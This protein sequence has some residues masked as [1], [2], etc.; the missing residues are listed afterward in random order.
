MLRYYATRWEVTGSIPDDITRFYFSIYLI[1]RA[2]LWS[3]D[4]FSLYQKWVPGI[5][6]G[7]KA[8]PA[9]KALNLTVICEPTVLEN[10]C[11]S[12]LLTI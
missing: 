11:E 1:L 4:L 7:D 12:P 10:T 2:A 3:W 5:F 9:C 6:L 8:R